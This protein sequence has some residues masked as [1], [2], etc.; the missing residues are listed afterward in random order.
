[1]EFKL[2]A[3]ASFT[4]FKLVLPRP[5]KPAAAIDTPPPIYGGSVILHDWKYT[6]R[7]G[8]SVD[9]GIRD[10]SPKDI[11]PFKGLLTGKE[12]GQR[13]KIWI[14]PGMD[15]YKITFEKEGAIY[16]G[17]AI[18]MR[19]SDD[20][21]AGMTVKIVIDPGPD[22]TDGKHPLEGYPHGRR[23][24]QILTFVAWAMADD[25][26]LV[27]PSK[28]RKKTRFADLSDVK[29]ANI[30]C[31][32]QIFLNFLVDNEDRLIG[33]QCEVRPE[34]DPVEFGSRV[35]RDYLCVESRSEM[36]KDTFDGAA[37]RTRWRKLLQDYFNSHQYLTR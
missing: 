25:E 15:E 30:L 21:S 27:D 37:A 1:M 5:P 33:K 2:A 11:H 20:S 9:L 14:G 24:G 22:G 8:M 23:E 13:M 18:L 29:Q 6:A 3:P 4:M 26:N 35:V 36:N 12:S 34:V 19:W 16:K 28:T 10:V 7:T 31:R 32:D 17:E